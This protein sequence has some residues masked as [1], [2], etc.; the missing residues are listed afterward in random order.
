MGCHLWGHT[1]GHDL[2]D[3]AAAAAAGRSHMLKKIGTITSNYLV[4]M[5]ISG[6]V[7]VSLEWNCGSAGV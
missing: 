4:R 1:V 2:S 3:L 7:F 6:I 5:P